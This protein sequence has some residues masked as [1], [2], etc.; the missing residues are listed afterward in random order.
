VGQRVRSHG[1]IDTPV[2]IVEDDGNLVR[3]LSRAVRSHGYDVLNET[4]GNTGL[5]T[6]L[7]AQPDAV[8][9]DL[10]LPGLRGLSILARLRASAEHLPSS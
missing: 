1:W 8:L 6:A 10:G 9:L 4:R 5:Q 7:M 3:S 2:L